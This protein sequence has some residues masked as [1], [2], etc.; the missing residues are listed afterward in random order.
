[1]AIHGAMAAIRASSQRR[2]QAMSSLYSHYYG[3]DLYQQAKKK[4][5]EEPDVQ[6]EIEEVKSL[7]MAQ[8]IGIGVFV[9]IVVV[10]VLFFWVF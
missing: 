2:R 8:A 10:V 5:D 4:V 6:P 3:V 9:G 7:E 1:M